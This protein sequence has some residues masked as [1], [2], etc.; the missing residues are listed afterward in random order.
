M[1]RYSDFLNENVNNHYQIGQILMLKD[2]K[3]KKGNGEEIIVNGP[4]EILSIEKEGDDIRYKVNVDMKMDYEST[5][6]SK[7]VEDN[8]QWYILHNRDK[9]FYELIK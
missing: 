6:G 3:R 1:K 4:G 2:L 5:Y 8:T 9:Q 7:W